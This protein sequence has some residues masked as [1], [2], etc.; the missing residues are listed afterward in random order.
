MRIELREAPDAIRR[1]GSELSAPIAEL[2]RLLTSQA[3]HVVVTCARGSSAHAATFAKHLIERHL[4]IPVA[5]AAPNIATVYLRRLDLKDQFFLAISQSG[6]SDDLVEY[7]EM[8]KAAGART[9]AIVNDT[10]SALA[11][12]CEIVLPM[13]AGPELSVAATKTFVAALG[14]LLQL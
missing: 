6:R 1:Q 5:A 8:A 3:V 4:G 7:A 11:A 9:A 13:D 2:V 10:A 12:A 14:A